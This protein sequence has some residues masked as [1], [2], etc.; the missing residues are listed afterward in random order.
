V[1]STNSYTKV[2]IIIYV[3]VFIGG[4]L[5]LLVRVAA[6][7]FQDQIYGLKGGEVLG[8]ILIISPLLFGYKGTEIIT[9]EL[10][11]RIV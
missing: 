11:I 5:V 1:L 8:G 9:N 4:L 6:V 10:F 2:V 7:S 3:L